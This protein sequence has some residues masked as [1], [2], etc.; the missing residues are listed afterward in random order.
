MLLLHGYAGSQDHWSEVCEILEKDF[1][2]VIPNL[3]PINWGRERYSFS[4]QIHLISRLILIEFPMQ[5]IHIA[6]L[7]FG[8]A[9]AW[10]F[11]ARY[12]NLVS[13]LSLFNPMPPAHQ[14]EFRNRIFR[15]VLSLPLTDQIVLMFLKT[16]IGRFLL[17]Q[18][19]QT[20]RTDRINRFSV[21]AVIPLRKLQ[22]VSYLISHF[23]WLMRNENWLSWSEALKKLNVPVQVTYDANDSIISSKSYKNFLAVIKSEVVHELKDSGHLM[24]QT[25]P[26]EIANILTEFHRAQVRIAKELKEAA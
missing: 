15:K 8:G 3:A 5:K 20:F 9:L 7:S 14:L 13:H 4:L 6:G 2:V 16:K 23:S 19:H 22:F 21:T 1:N 10:G 25:R 18:A 17:H 12:S 24:S 11:A 26:Q